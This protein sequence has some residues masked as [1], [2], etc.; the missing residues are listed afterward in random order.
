MYINKNFIVVIFLFFSLFS[1]GQQEEGK[2]DYKQGDE[3]L[4]N[5]LLSVEDPRFSDLN[6]KKLFV[7]VN[8]AVSIHFGFNDDISNAN[9]YKEIYDCTIKLSIIPYNN[10]GLKDLSYIENGKLKQHDDPFIITLKITHDN[11][12]KGAKL[13]DYLVY[14]L[15][16]IHKATVQVTSI[17]YS[18]PGIHNAPYLALKFNT[19]RYYNLQNTIALPS[20]EFIK[21]TGTTASKASA[22]SNADEL[23]IKWEKNLNAPALEYELEWTWIDNFGANGIAKKDSKDIALSEKD[24]MLNSTRIQTKETSYRIPIVYS[25]G[26]VIYRVRAVGRFLDD[27]TKVYNGRW[28]VSEINKRLNFVSDWTYVEIDQSHELGAKNWQ[29]QASFAEDGKKKE[30]VSYFD[31]SLRNRQTVTKINSNNKAIV[32]EVIY[33]NQGRAAIEVLPSPLESSAIHF[34][35]DLNKN[36]KGSIFSHKDFDWDLKDSIKNCQPILVPTIANGDGSGKYYST[37]NTISNTFQDL[38]PD[39]QGYPFSQIEYT[40]DNTGRI[41]SKGGVGPDHQIGKGHEMRYFYSQ[42]S[43]E[44][45]NRLFGYKV[46]DYSHYKKNTIIDPN[47]QI[48][49]SYLDPQGRTVATAMAGDRQGSLEALDDEK[50]TS[51]HLT[52]TSNLLSNNDPYASGENSVL[53]DGIKLNSVISVINS[54][55]VTFEYSFDKTKNA[56]TDACLNGKFYPFVYDW[57][58]SLKNDCADELLTGADALSAKIGLYSLSANSSS[59]LSFPAR[60]FNALDQGKFLSVGAYSLSKDLSIDNTIL[61]LYA[62]DYIKQLKDNKICLP[63]LTAL[64]ADV[65][66]ADCTITCRSCEEGLVRSHLTDAEYTS[67]QATLSND[68]KL[69]D[70]S[71]RESYIVIAENN[72]VKKNMLTV[73]ELNENDRDNY[74]KSFKFEF[75]GLLKGCRELCEQPVN[76][77]NLNLDMLLRDV[78]P[79]GQYGSVQGLEAESDVSDED[80]KNNPSIDAPL[81]PVSVF[82]INNDLSYG[83]FSTETYKDEDTGLDVTVKISNN[84][85]KNPEGGFYK[86]EDGSISYVKVKLI[87]KVAGHP[88]AAVFE[89]ALEGVSLTALKHD[90]QSEDPND[91]LAEPKYLKEVAY[92][93]S[94]WRNSWANALVKF[95]PEYQY[96][97]YNL[98]ICDKLNSAG[99]NSNSFDAELFQKESY[100]AQTKK[101]DESVYASNGILEKLLNIDTTEDPFYN[102][103]N[104]YNGE[105]GEN[106][107]D[108]AVRKDIMR[109]AL[110][111]NFDG[112]KTGTKKMNM[113]QTAYYFAVFSNGIAPESA[114]NSFMNLSQAD[115]LNTIRALG[116]NNNIAELTTKERIWAN[117]K[118]N[119]VGLKDKT[120]TVLAHISAIKNNNYNECIGN[121]ESSDNFVTLLKKYT[122]VASGK[123]KTNYQRILDLIARTPN[124]DA[125][126]VPITNPSSTKVEL[127]CSDALSALFALKEKRFIGAD[128]GYDSSMDDMDLLGVAT[129][130]ADSR[131]YLETGKSPNYLALENFL[132]GMVDRT[133]QSQGLVVPQGIPTTSMPYLTRSLFDAQV[134][135]GFNLS[136]SLETPKIVS[137]KDTSNKLAIGFTSGDLPISTPIILEFINTSNHVNPCGITTALDWK[138]IVDFKNLYYL[139]NSYDRNFGTYKFQIIATIKREGT[140]PD[141]YTPEEVLVEGTTKINIADYS[142]ANALSASCGKQERFSNAFNELIL[143]L[144]NSRTLMGSNVNLVNNS[145]FTNGYLYEYLGI[146]PGDMVTWNNP[147]YSAGYNADITVNYQKRITLQ[148]GNTH[149]GTKAI[150]RVSI[151]SL[152]ASSSSNL[153]KIKLKGLI[154]IRQIN[155]KISTGNLKAPLYFTCCA[156]CGE[157]DHDGNGI[158]DNC[159]NGTSVSYCTKPEPER[160]FENNLL[161]VL[162][163]CIDQYGSQFP[164]TGSYSTP[165]TLS[166]NNAAMSKFIEASRLIEF[167]QS[168]RNDQTTDPTYKLPVTLTNYNISIMPSFSNMVSIGWSDLNVGADV[169]R[170]FIDIRDLPLF[171]VATINSLDII[172]ENRL[173]IVYT[174]KIGNTVTVYPQF[175]CLTSFTP[176]S[177]TS[178]SFDFCRSLQDYIP[179]VVPSMITTC[180]NSKSEESNYEENLRDVISEAIE[181]NTFGISQNS[182]ANLKM[183][184]FIGESGLIEKFQVARNTRYAQRP[185]GYNTPIELTSFTVSKSIPEGGDTPFYRIVFKNSTNKTDASISLQ[186]EDANAIKKIG[187]LDITDEVSAKV[188]YTDINNK[189]VNEEVNIYNNVHSSESAGYSYQICNFFSFKLA[190][191]RASKSA[192]RDFALSDQPYYETIENE[193]G[194]IRIT[195]Y[196]LPSVTSRSAR[197]LS[198]A[199]AACPAICVPAIPEPVICTEK[200]S[201]FKAELNTIIP[202]YVLDENLNINGTYFCEANFGYISD[203]YLYYLTKLKEFKKGS[204][205]SSNALF[206]DIDKFGATRLHYG[207]K[208]THGVINEYFNYLVRIDVPNPTE[209]AITWNQFAD[210]YVADYQKCVPAVMIP[211]FSLEDQNASIK[212]PCELYAATVKASNKQQLEDTFFSAKRE[213]FIRNYTKEALEGI[214]E[215]L[216]KTASDK[217]YQYTLYYYDQAGNLIQTVPPE[218]VKRLAPASDLTIDSVRANDT[219]KVDLADV[220]GIKV[221]PLNDMQTQYRYNSLNQLVWQQTPDAG[222]TVFA[223]DQLGRIIASQNEKQK[224]LSQLSYTRYD[225]LGRIMEA[226]QLT[227]K[228]PAVINELGRLAVSHEPKADLI[229]VDAVEDHYPYNVTLKTEQVTKTLYDLPMQ[230]SETW[231]TDYG[232]NNSHKRVTAI[233]YYDQLMQELTSVEASSAYNNAILY[234]Y[235][236]HGNVKEML[237]H[238]NNNGDLTALNQQVKKIVYDYDLISGNVNKVTYQPE[239][240]DQFI[241]KYDYDADNR[242]QQVYTSKDNTIWEKE[243]NYLYYDHGPLARVEIGDKKVQGLDYIYTLQGW[244]KGVNSEELKI[245]SDAGKDGL[246]VAKDAFGFA[247]NYYKGDYLSRSNTTDATVFSLTKTGNNESAANLYNGNIKDMVT[248]LADLNGNPLA[249]QFNHYTY[250]QL[251]RIKSMSSQ[252]ILAGVSTP[253]YKSN[254]WYDRNGNLQKLNRFA[255]KEDGSIVEMDHLTYNYLNKTHLDRDPSAYNYKTRTNQLQNVKDAV[256][257]GIFTNSK[258]LN[259]TSLDIDNQSDDNYTYD[260]IGQLTSDKLE[261]IDIDWR[262]DGKVNKVTK[263]NGTVISFEYDGLGNRTSKK[264]VTST[265]T[266]ITYY[267]RDAQGNPMSTYEMVTAAGV[268]N[269]Y[270]V[271]QSIYGSSRL[272]IE[273]YEHNKE[274]SKD[275]FAAFAEKSNLMSA[276]SAFAMVS[277]ES[278]PPTF[279]LGFDTTAGFTTWS[280]SN[281]K[282]NLFNNK[283]LKT[284]AVTLSSHFKIGSTNS[285]NVDLSVAALNGISKEGS[286]PKSNSFSYRSTI[287]LTVR[288][289]SAG[290]VP[291]VS[292]IKYR[293]VHHDYNRKG[294]KKYSFRS[295]LEQVDYTIDT[296]TKAIPEGEWDFNAEVKLNTKTA[297]YE[298][299]IT[300][301]GNIYSTV[302]KTELLLTGEND[303][304]LKRN[305]RRLEI[306]MPDNT[307]GAAKI[308]DRPNEY[309][310]NKLS[311]KNEMC[312]FTY[313]ISNGKGTDPIKINAF[314]FDEGPGITNNVNN[315]PISSTNIPMALNSIGYSTTFCGLADK[316]R[317]GDGVIDKDDICPD[318]FNPKQEDTT[319]VALGF[320]PDK[321][322][323]VCD[324]C[325]Y[326][327]PF[328]T[329]TDGDGRGDD[330][331]IEGIVRPCDNCK[332]IPNYDQADY[333]KDGVGDVCDNCK[334]INNPLQ[335]DA[336]NNGIGDA[337]EG[338]DQGVGKTTVVAI[339]ETT[340]RL[341]G[342]K[343]YELS[344]HLGN[345]LSV[346]S[347]R[348]LIKVAN[349]PSQETLDNFSFTGWTSIT[350][351]ANWNRLGASNTVSVTTNT[352]KLVASV[353]DVGSGISYSMSTIAGKK[354]TITY[355]LDLISSSG[356]NLKVMNFSNT[357]AQK[358]DNISGRQSITFTAQGVVS[359]LQWYRT[360]IKDGAFE[361]FAMDNVTTSVES[362]ENTV[363]FTTFSPDIFSYSDYYPFGML[364]PNRHKSVNDYRYGFNGMEKDNELKGGEGN[365]YDF[366]ARMLDPRIGR[367]FARDPKDKKNPFLSPYSYVENNP[368]FF[369]DPDGK[370]AIGTVKGNTITIS[371][372]IY[373]T[374]K[375]GA[376]NFIKN[377]QAAVNQYYQGKNDFKAT[378]GG[379]KYNVKFDIVV[380]EAPSN[381]AS[382]TPS[383]N[384]KSDVLTGTSHVRLMPSVDSEGKETRSHVANY[385]MGEINVNE[386]ISGIAHEF[387]HLLGLADQYADISVKEGNKKDIIYMNGGKDD[388][389]AENYKNTA[390]SELMGK[391]A[392][393]NIDGNEK[394]SQKD[395]DALASF[396]LS[397]QKNGKAIIEAGSI[398][399]GLAPPL[400]TDKALLDKKYE[401]TDKQVDHHD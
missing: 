352:N 246:N 192:L 170:N 320:A 178:K 216:T 181:K 327:N 189:A 45:L 298:V 162:N 100:N 38:V 117:F 96:Y 39:A 126:P 92:F 89:P 269:Y 87:S 123:T 152:L 248:T 259:D 90:P 129:A 214:T 211:R 107:E 276:R 51:L 349:E 310:V 58:I 354:Y 35:N 206:L 78:S 340:I 333:D 376:K 263:K 306:N 157:D 2:T 194:T 399:K 63:D 374:G 82:N 212:T 382:G 7:S 332:L 355:D 215:K 292:L 177:T 184:H 299:V 24:F 238:T 358:T 389:I 193:D 360:K 322:G 244:L 122:G 233:L 98:G 167:F 47:G 388:I 14:K 359:N 94:N 203:D 379:K 245:N 25:S 230:N 127:A 102:S 268:S 30:V 182:A 319:E 29:Y 115:L 223:Y 185:V 68:N 318:V 18:S 373:V 250:D 159:D 329:D 300:L 398:G 48:S 11:V 351:G 396:V 144:Q 191:L 128:Y 266:T 252:S 101:I 217:E 290:Y 1:F 337:C 28:S 323:D 204:I 271:E 400:E 109:E 325:A 210:K 277:Q 336:N 179:V 225:K 348:K 372:V 175:A 188:Y 335:E 227:L 156:P 363:A 83:G 21:Y 282:L 256:G 209:E 150:S 265:S 393:D 71:R 344:N 49:V 287:L 50:D 77:C 357:I 289:E 280:D 33:D 130:E 392:N 125:V 19:D 133:I 273:Q 293:R 220:N 16:G 311:L 291:T 56:F 154:G 136:T 139:P 13:N 228:T 164:A 31:G 79:H 390:T 118:A 202:G 257:A 124:P 385:E 275:D 40:A 132:K 112:M 145:N 171:N 236:V 190:S 135:S 165:N 222:V 272:G 6:D 243:A 312:D 297:A 52:T 346:I 149:L 197:S 387:G 105:N 64:E 97:A 343:R 370:D 36:T 251:N 17:T 296:K 362:T 59:A 66:A 84:S 315:H 231:F 234:D 313:S 151:G 205:K 226:G 294:K 111:S 232:V 224:T 384:K 369:V 380:K 160:I 104:S 381:Y 309:K 4:K 44:E 110:T 367:W 86:E 339:P 207:N 106:G 247:L 155:A 262:V 37:N 304:N 140:S 22:A 161:N 331:I 138:D 195:G 345:V 338:L 208:D 172:N 240:V 113:L 62:D 8:D 67:F 288:K 324:N 303:E 76:V 328:Q 147:G 267:E 361:L 295:Y 143:D 103:P 397:N 23:I 286:F 3:L 347:D 41:K 364:V 302:S 314:S 34:Y 61:N 60:T 316:D 201:A 198:K 121:P 305:D 142:P 153:V 383:C 20:A 221:V 10:L 308:E 5:P 88:E 237:H 158:G 119:Y 12:T 255:P 334:T 80:V 254:Y 163:D 166:V 85:W 196:N 42:P 120:R 350:D 180:E 137:T 330:V 183:S 199:V 55:A 9:A 15:P 371:T 377:A 249:S 375:N 91:Y 391:A 116:I 368:M 242:I 378:V 108:F 219:E 253:S 43:Q 281:S 53:K 307:L 168:G 241:H 81:D 278:V 229:K 46:G 141:C 174:D 54:K 401:G 274:I 75:R 285:A 69:G 72:Y 186:I 321:V 239:K 173:K 200:W 65:T 146:Q 283:S 395:I 70:V 148:L 134:N 284:K 386:I 169:G 187:Y 365:S 131:V 32:G 279:G 114:Y 74:E 264:V 235:D 260:A 73:L 261:G 342:D 93:V 394:L 26:Y 341:V 353:S 356:I 27:L 95:H 366:G 258:N 270:L 176:R 99:L 218:G 301:N 326:P 213:E 317:D 57:S